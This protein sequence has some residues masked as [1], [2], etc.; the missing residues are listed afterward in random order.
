MNLTIA[1]AAELLSMPEREIID[2]ADS[3]AG[4][5]ITTVG[6]TVLVNCVEPD[7]EGKTGLMFLAAPTATY[8]GAFPVY[9]QPGGDTDTDTDTGD[10]VPTG[11]ISKI[12]DWVQAVDG[13]LALERANDALAA[14]EAGKNRPSLIAAL[15]DLI[16]TTNE[17]DPAATPDP[18]ADPA[19]SPEK[20]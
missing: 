5:L 14:E 15:N 6:G 10:G 11:S 3:P 20:E 8:G 2:V 9:A 12:L 4:D 18:E 1:E 17:P 19:A 16:A 13:E 7:A